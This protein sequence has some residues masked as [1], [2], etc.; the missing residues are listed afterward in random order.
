MIFGYAD[1]PYLGSAKTFYAALHPDAGDFDK[2]ETHAA[3]IERLS[4]DFPDGWA[5][6]MQSTNLRTLLPLCPSDVRVLAWVKP[7]ASWKPGTT[8]AYCWEPVIL[9]GGRKLP[10]NKGGWTTRDYVA[11]PVTLRAGFPGAK[12][13]GF[14]FWL[15][16]VFCAQPDD[17]IVDLFPG[18]GA[19][20]RAWDRWRGGLFRCARAPTPSL[21]GED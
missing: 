8:P 1:P 7:F 3:L 18:S 11:C 15:F 21:Y 13:E 16:D 20:G 9:R 12:P 6:S 10:H 19:I 4:V 5:L 14:A 2:V 17:E